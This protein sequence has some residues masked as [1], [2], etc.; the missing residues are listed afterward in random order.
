LL[1]DQNHVSKITN[2]QKWSN[3]NLNMLAISIELSK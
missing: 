2:L 3:H 1:L